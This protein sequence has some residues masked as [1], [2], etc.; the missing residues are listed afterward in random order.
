M[1]PIDSSTLPGVP[2]GTPGNHDALPAPS[3]ASGKAV[4]AAGGPPIDLRIEDRDNGQ[5][6]MIAPSSR[7]W[8]FSSVGL[9]ANRGYIARLAPSR[10]LAITRISF[11]VTGAAG[12]DDACEVAILDGST[13]RIVSSGART[14]LLNSLGP[15]TIRIPR[16]ALAKGTVYYPML[17]SVSATAVLLA[18]AYFS[19]NAMRLFGSAGPQLDADQ[20]AGVYPIPAGPMTLGGVGSTTV[21]VLALRDALLYLGAVGDS[22]TGSAGDATKWPAKLEALLGQRADLLVSGVGG[23]TTTQILARLATDI[24]YYRPQQCTVLAGINDIFGGDPTATTIGNLRAIYAALAAVSCAP[25]AIKVFPFG[26]ASFWSA[27]N[28]A[29]RQ[30][31]NAWIDSQAPTYSVVDLE[32]VVGDLT[33]PARPVIKAA[34][35]SGDG[36]HLNAAGYQAVADALYA[37]VYSSTLQYR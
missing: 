37:R 26:N 29:K 18:A 31:I 34:Y 14:G 15:K 10:D 25:I 32:T 2:L 35:D 28:E 36:L 7:G 9:A 3:A 24:T 33:D 11:V 16:T 27:G 19:A 5:S 4:D 8:F 21:P 30:T 13:N 12:A 17:S 22:L 1:S 6:G 20:I 23:N